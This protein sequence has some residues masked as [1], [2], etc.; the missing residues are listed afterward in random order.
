MSTQKDIKADTPELVKEK[1][2]ELFFRLG[3]R[4]VSMDDIAKQFGISKKTIYEFFDDKNAIVDAVVQELV[5]SH[6]HVF[7]TSRQNSKDAIDEVIKQDTGVSLLCRSA[8]PSFFYQLQ[9]Y[10]PRAWKRVEEYKSQMHNFINANLR[11][12]KQERLYRADIDVML[13][14]DLRMHQVVNV[15]Q[16]HLLSGHNLSADYL[17]GEFTRLYLYSITS[18]K[19]RELLHKYLDEINATKN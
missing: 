12:G 19:G 9:I 15:F 5:T 16:P 8:R 2:K 6:E 11:R 14:S 13:I 1:A 17:A 4:S 3:L 18:G 7:R 10:F